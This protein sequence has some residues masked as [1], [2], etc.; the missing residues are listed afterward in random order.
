MTE[1]EEMIRRL[2]D[3]FSQNSG[4]SP[5]QREILWL[6]IGGLHR[7]ESAARLECSVKTVEGYWKRICEKTGCQCQAEVIAK[8][9]HSTLAPALQEAS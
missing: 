2:V 8:F 3:D 9:I 7:K 6:A 1:S 4:L 5:R